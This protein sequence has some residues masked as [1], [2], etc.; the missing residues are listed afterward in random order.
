MHG[1]H[2]HLVHGPSEPCDGITCPMLADFRE[3]RATIL[4]A[5]RAGTIVRAV[6]SESGRTITHRQAVEPNGVD[7]LPE[8]T[9]GPTAPAPARHRILSH[10]DETG[11]SSSLVP[12]GGAL[13]TYWDANARQTE[14]ARWNSDA[15]RAARRQSRTRP[16]VASDITY[17]G[18]SVYVAEPDTAERL[19][20]PTVSH[21]VTA[22]Y[23][24]AVIERRGIEALMSDDGTAGLLPI[25]PANLSPEPSIGQAWE[26]AQVTYQQSPYGLHED[27]LL[28]DVT[29]TLADG[30]SETVDADSAE[31][32]VTRGK[33]RTVTCAGR[34]GRVPRADACGV[35]KTCKGRERV[36][37]HARKARHAERMARAADVMSAYERARGQRAVS[38][39]QY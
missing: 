21:A 1:E 3:R 34:N 32:L 9:T 26:S 10:D 23:E 12:N 22:A 11:W 15:E 25:G 6:T 37:R 38:A 20:L 35:C 28:G 19:H 33:G 5:V 29:V 14:R 31:S 8:W 27:G 18:P 7:A 36:N 2:S 4:Q 24:S 13:H 16:L 17:A 39:R 30:T